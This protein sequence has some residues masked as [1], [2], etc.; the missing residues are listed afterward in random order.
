MTEPEASPAPAP[1]PRS[2]GRGPRTARGRRGERKRGKGG[3][4]VFLLVS[5][6]PAAGVVWYLLQ[7]PETQQK[8]IGLFGDGAGGRAAKAG[9]CLVVLV[10]LA[11]IALPAFHASSGALR[12][13]MARIRA[14]PTAVRVLLFPVELVIWLLWFLVQILFAVDAVLILATGALVIILVIRIVDPSV[15][16]DVLPPILS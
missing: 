9:I 10:A 14:K 2:S 7:T 16:A 12:G 4:I 13:V 11:R 3:L 6:V 5:A 8:L 1:S 15:L